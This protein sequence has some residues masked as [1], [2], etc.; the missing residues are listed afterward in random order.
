MTIILLAAILCGN[1]APPAISPSYLPLRHL[2]SC[3]QS[4]CCRQEMDLDRDRLITFDEFYA[5]LQRW[6]DEKL[7]ATAAAQGQGRVSALLDPR[8]GGAAAALLA[9]L[10][11]EDV[12]QLRV[13]GLV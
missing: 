1:L 10:P 9:D 6:V 3:P 12:A 2:P 11:A 7:A 8:R 4:L 5:C 13:C